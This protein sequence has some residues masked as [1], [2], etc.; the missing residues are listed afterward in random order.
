MTYS[1]VSSLAIL[2]VFLV[3]ECCRE[4]VDPVPGS[5]VGSASSAPGGRTLVEESP[6]GLLAPRNG[7]RVPRVGDDGTRGRAQAPGQGLRMR[8]DRGREPPGRGAAA[9]R[10]AGPS[11]RQEGVRGPT[12]A[13]RRVEAVSGRRASVRVRRSGRRAPG[14]RPVR[15]ASGAEAARATVRARPCRFCSPGGA[16][17]L[18]WAA[19][20]RRR[21]AAG[22]RARP[23]PPP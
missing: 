2:T 7:S 6:E 22:G 15:V 4:A 16:T 12:R 8:R 13:P 3:V 5:P 23:S 21:R 19:L 20:F 9:R 10:L 1:K 18:R 11:S 14:D 17:P